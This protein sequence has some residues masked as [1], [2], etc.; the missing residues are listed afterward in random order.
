MNKTD[1]NYDD[2]VTRLNIN[3]EYGEIGFIHNSVNGYCVWCN[4]ACTLIETNHYPYASQQTDSLIGSWDFSNAKSVEIVILYQTYTSSY[5]YLCL[6]FEDRYVNYN[7]TLTTNKYK[8]GGDDHTV[9]AIHLQS[10]DM[11]TGNALFTSDNYQNNYYGFTIMIL[12]NY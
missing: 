1:S 6:N 10:V 7:G 4:R 8:F 11:L 12:P 5:D 3:L 9:R 2:L